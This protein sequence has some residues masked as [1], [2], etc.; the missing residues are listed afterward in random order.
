MSLSGH[1]SADTRLRSF[2]DRV[3]RLKEEQ[4]TLADDIREVYAE[5]KGE[6]YDKTAMGSLVAHL[7][8]V[9]KKGA[10]A[11]NEADTVFSVY[12]DSYQR[13]S[14]TPVA[15]PAHTHERPR[16]DT[17]ISAETS[18]DLHRI[19]YAPGAVDIVVGNEGLAEPAC[20]DDGQA[21]NTKSAPTPDDDFEPPAFLKREQKPLR[22]HCLNREVCAGQG[23]KHCHAC[24]KAAGIERNAA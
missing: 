13:A 15:T 6:G 14:G 22:P 8:K 18:A 16:V 3:L 21:A 2:I 17:S 12:L 24:S 7:R 20:A 19:N 10:D 9:E 23:L 11:V 1:N 4:D 5:A